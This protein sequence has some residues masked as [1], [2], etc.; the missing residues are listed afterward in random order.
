MAEM[1]VLIAR[2]LWALTLLTLLDPRGAA[3]KVI[4]FGVSAK[5][6]WMLLALISVSTS[7]F[8]SAALNLLPLPGGEFSEMLLMIRQSP[9][10]HQPVLYAGLNYLQALLW[11]HMLA[12]C[13]QWL[14][15]RGTTNEVVAV[16]VWMQVIWIF[17]TLALTVVFLALPILAMV[18]FTAFFF[19]SL[20]MIVAST[21]AAH[22]FES[23]FMYKAIATVVCAAGLV[24]MTMRFVGTL[25]GAAI[26][27]TG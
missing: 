12:L 16:V 17:M 22:E 4:E 27:G 21:D 8:V 10:F 15:G 23:P 5:A 1:T 9:A 7:M 24:L 18:M 6:F 25:V 14:G 19:W 20:W 3:R 13:G 26:I 2:L 11:V